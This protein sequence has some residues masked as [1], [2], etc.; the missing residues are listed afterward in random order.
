MA[1]DPSAFSITADGVRVRLRLTPKASAN[2]ISGIR[3]DKEGECVLKAQVTSVPEGGKANA[4][5]IRML[6]KEWN[7]A[8]SRIEIIQG[9]TDRNKTLLV[10]G[11]PQDV[12]NQLHDWAA[13]NL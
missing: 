4:A 8:K 3:L 6:A 1:A 5:L 13:K 9:T 2:R 7:L 12:L 11:N 10:A